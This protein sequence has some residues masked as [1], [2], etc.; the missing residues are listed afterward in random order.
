MTKRQGF[1]VGALVLSLSGFF[2]KLIGAIFRIPLTNLVGSAAMGYF[3]SAYSVY[4]FLLALATSGIP[5]GIAAMVSKSLALNKYRDIKNIMRIASL[6]FIIFSAVL[7]ILGLIFS[8]QIASLMN[9]KEAYYSVFNIMPAI[10]FIAV[11]SIFKGFFQGYNNMTPTAIS[12]II[13][14]IVKLVAGCGIAYYMFDKGYPEEQVVGGAIMG[15]T[16]GTVCATIFLFLR[17]IF[18]DKSY[19]ISIPNFLADTGTPQKVLLKEFLLMSFPIMVS[20]VTANLMSAVDAF[21]VMNRLKGYLPIEEAKLLWGAYS[22]MALTIFNLPSFLIISIGV[23]LV[24]SMAAA[25]AMKN[26]TRIKSTVN[27]ALKYSSILAFAC[28][29]GLNAISERVLLLLFSGDPA[30]VI[31]ARPL[32]EIIS[33]ALISVGLT[34]V[35][36][37]I[38]QAVGK[39]YL[40]VI[41]VAVGAAIKTICTFVLV[42]IPE[43]N[44]NGAPIA[45]NIAYPVMMFLNI[46]FIYKNMHILPNF[47]D[48]IFKPLISGAV[49]F[50]SAK[51]FM[52][53]FDLFLSPKLA[54]LPVI[55]LTALVYFALLLI[56]KLVS[57]DEILQYFSKGKKKS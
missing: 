44:I 43:I 3:S 50:T 10:F 34:N 6:L 14:A 36:G 45:T 7:T 37:S 28:A 51:L 27:K 38:L 5:T 48:V 40:S 55:I 29:F 35:T 24:P 23:S 57:L 15:V 16:L 8:Q 9:S 13:E 17:Y 11:V 26:E 46:Y 53:F 4:V 31:A 20:S 25:F 12:N 56:L 2:S 32:L 19:R 33:F 18:R 52:A 41:S 42:G 47:N 21:F 54:V 1:V 39:A 49:C 30:G 22:N